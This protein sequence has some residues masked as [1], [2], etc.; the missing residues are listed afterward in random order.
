MKTGPN[1]TSGP[2]NT[3]QKHTYNNGPTAILDVSSYD[4]IGRHLAPTFRKRGWSSKEA[5]G[6]AGSRDTTCLEA[7]VCF[8]FYFLFNYTNM[9]LDTNHMIYD[10]YR[11]HCPHH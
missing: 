9:Y 10:V 5:E 3:P 7:L 11:H 8:T 4:Q 6:A 2:A 1:D